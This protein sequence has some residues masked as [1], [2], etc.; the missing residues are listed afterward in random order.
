MMRRFLP[1]LLP[2]ALAI[3]LAA[4]PTDGP[5]V[6]VGDWGADHLRLTVGATAS[7][8]EYDCAHGTI[9]GPLIVRTDGRFEGAGTHVRE[10][11]GPIRDGEAADAHP[12]RYTGRVAGDGMTLTV[13][14]LDASGIAP[15]QYTLRR[16]V[17]GHVF[18]CLT[19]GQANDHGN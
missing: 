7:A 11:G 5:P 18:K 6:V 16:G 12:A 2:I 4:C 8:L 14:V 19:V 13:T 9:D 1:P 15:G 3:V 10:H 17:T